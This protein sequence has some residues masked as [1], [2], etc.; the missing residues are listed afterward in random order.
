[1]TDFISI[2]DKTENGTSRTYTAQ[3]KDKLSLLE[4]SSKHYK[5]QFP[6]II[7]V[8]FTASKINSKSTSVT[9]SKQH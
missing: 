8:T 6:E 7:T 2:K 1:V 5:F 9:F 3:G 4:N